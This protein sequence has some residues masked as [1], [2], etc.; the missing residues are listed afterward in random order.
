MFGTIARLRPKPGRLDDLLAYGRRHG[1]VSVPGYHTSY[2][3]RPMDNPYREE[4]VFLV[5]MFEDEDA[6][7]ANADSP[8]QHERYLELRELLESDPDWMDGHFEMA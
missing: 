1:T 2:L 6:Y 5:A 7:R 4:T 8:A 3:F